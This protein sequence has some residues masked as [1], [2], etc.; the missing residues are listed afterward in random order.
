[1]RRFIEKNYVPGK[2]FVTNFDFCPQI[3]LIQKTSLMDFT[4]IYGLRKES[5]SLQQ[6]GF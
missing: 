6:A 5:S 1:M 4:K 2:K 3:R